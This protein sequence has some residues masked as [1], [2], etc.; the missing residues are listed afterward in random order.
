MRDMDPT[1]PI[2][3]LGTPDCRC[4]L[5]IKLCVC[6]CGCLG[7]FVCLTAIS[8]QLSP[9][10]CTEPEDNQAEYVQVKSPVLVCMCVRQSFYH[11]DAVF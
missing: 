5:H 9:F 7:V 11:F 10:S 4:V 1:E 2:M 6:L 3:K 8:R